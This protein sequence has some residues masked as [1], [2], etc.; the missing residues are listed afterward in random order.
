MPKIS[1]DLE[2]SRTTALR[3]K[4]RLDPKA[5]GLGL[6]AESVVKGILARIKGGF[7]PEC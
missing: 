7:Q 5:V 1:S 4:A 3:K 2:A 6:V